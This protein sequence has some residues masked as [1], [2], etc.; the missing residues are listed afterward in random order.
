MKETKKRICVVLVTENLDYGGAERQVVELANNMDRDRFDTHVCALSD[1]V[2]LSSKLRDAEQRLHII[3]PINSFDFTVI[4]RLA[5]LLRV[6]KADIVH[7]YLFTA[8]L[9]SRVAGRIAGTKLIVGSERNANRVIEKHYILGLKITRR[10]VDIIIA[11]STA[12]AES[13]S[14]IFNRPA[15]DYRVVHNGVDTQRFKPMDGTAFRRKLGIPLQCPVVGSI[16]CIRPQKNHEMLFRAFRLVLDSLPEAR[17]LLIGDPPAQ[18]KGKL[19]GYKARMH[20]IVNDVNIGHR[21]IF[22][23]HQANTE[24]LYPVCDITVLSSRFEGTAN[25]LLESMACGIP[26][27]ATNVS[28]N[29][30]IAKNGEVG[31]L[32]EVG[33][34]TGMANRMI[35]LLN[36]AAGRQE[37]GSKGRSWVV[38]EFSTKR[39]A[40]KV[41]SVYIEFLNGKQK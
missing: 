27:V 6:L 7:G 12:G 22:L 1:Y 41:E 28:D 20:R 17:L 40:E 18:S 2:P 14:Q 16:A 34:Y 23:G 15:S 35:S 3:K 26:F 5:Y 32:V 24:H 8:E 9:V 33:D 4:P 36:N 11:N 13:N 25:V 30:F 29:E 10:F 19:D 39:L 31:H 21:C 38:S 37:L